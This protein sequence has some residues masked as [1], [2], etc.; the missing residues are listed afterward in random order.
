MNKKHIYAVL[1][2]VV[3]VALIVL[4]IRLIGGAFSLLSGAVNAVLGVAVV[5]ALVIIVV[6]M[7]RYASAP[8]GNTLCIAKGDNEAWRKSGRKDSQRSIG[9]EYESTSPKNKKRRI[10]PAACAADVRERSF[11]SFAMFTRGCPWRRPLSFY[12]CVR[13]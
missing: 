6:W 4:M 5:L 1:A 2:A 12:V 8:A 7:F 9:E 11:V 10:F 13:R 3:A